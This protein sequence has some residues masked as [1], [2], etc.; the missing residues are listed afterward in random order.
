[1]ADDDHPIKTR[2]PQFTG[3]RE[4]Y[5]KWPMLFRAFIV[6]E[7]LRLDGLQG[8]P[9]N[10]WDKQSEQYNALTAAQK[11]AYDERNERVAAHLTLAMSSEQ[12]DT[13]LNAVQET[14]D[15]AVASLQRLHGL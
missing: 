5:Q 8:P 14:P 11:R 15:D 10:W 7:G 12:A 13:A 3:R 6:T 1:M 4:S 2:A 9:N